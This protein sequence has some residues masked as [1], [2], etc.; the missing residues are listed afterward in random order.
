MRN[1]LRTDLFDY[2]LPEELIALHPPKERDGGRLLVVSPDNAAKLEHKWIRDLPLAVPQNSLLVL[3]DTRVIRARLHGKRP[4]GGAVEL[5]LVRPISSASATCRWLALTRAN[6]PL[7]AGSVIEIDG[8]RSRVVER[9][10]QGEAVIEF[11]VS[12]QELADL[13]E[14]VGE[15]PLP[16]YLRRD[17]VPAD[18]ERYQTIFAKDL[19]SIAAPTAG[20]HFTEEVFDR[21]KAQHIDIAAI[22]LH[23]GPGTFRPI[24]AD[25]ISA[26]IMDAEEYSIGE[27]AAY[28]INKAK[29]EG[30]PIIAVGT[31][32]TRAL[33]SAFLEHGAI[34]ACRGAT[35]LFIAPGF[36][37]RVIDGLMTNFHLPRST[38]LCL[39]SALAGRETI[40]SA[41]REA[42]NRKYRFYSYGDAMLIMP[43]NK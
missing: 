42:I 30:R 35:E 24:A 26:H 15:V 36:V 27:E 3:N 12:E 5:L 29:A 18:I 23:V 9:L 17:P 14:R 41:Y 37:F 19:G 21:L 33:E 2:A 7:K 10:A 25:E 34:K 16:P 1:R 4:T 11:L 32:V 39:V 38:L 40:L 8:V 31:T 22:T 6:K 20:L 28:A 13:V 43:H